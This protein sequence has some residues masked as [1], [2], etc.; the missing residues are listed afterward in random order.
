MSDDSDPF[1]DLAE[2]DPARWA[3][4]VYDFT[5]HLQET[6]VRSLS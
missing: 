4:A 1:T 3:W 5:T 2:D 6:L